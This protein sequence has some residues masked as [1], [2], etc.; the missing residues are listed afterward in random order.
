MVLLLNAGANFRCVCDW[1]LASGGRHK[2]GSLGQFSL[3]YP[4][5]KLKNSALL[6][7]ACLEQETRWMTGK[8]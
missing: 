3:R 5:N 7:K 8:H 6:D 2:K 1:G 4:W